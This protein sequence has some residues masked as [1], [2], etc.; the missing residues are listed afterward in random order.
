MGNRR[1]SKFS[2]ARGN[3]SEG[4]VKVLLNRKM[5]S[6]SHCSADWVAVELS[7]A[8]AVI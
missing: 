5:S 4:K 6:A 1:K 3:S 7:K 8:T 2:A